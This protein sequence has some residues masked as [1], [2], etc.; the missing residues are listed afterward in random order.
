MCDGGKSW[1]EKLAGKAVGVL[2]VLVDL[3]VNGFFR[4]S[5]IGVSSH[6]S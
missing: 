6:K 3:W 1:Q 2:A 5:N 4:G